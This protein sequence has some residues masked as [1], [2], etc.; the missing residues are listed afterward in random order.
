VKKYLAVFIGV[1]FLLSFTA[2]AF[3]I[4]ETVEPDEAVVAKGPTKIILGGK[5]L[6]RGW[7]FDGVSNINGRNVVPGDFGSDA[8]YTTNVNLTVDAKVSD[9]L[10]G[11][12]EFETASGG[13]ANSGLYIWGDQGRGYDSKPNADILIR[14]AWIQ[15]TGSGLLG[16]PAGLKIGHM[17]ISL[18]E[19]QFLNNERFGDDAILVWVDPMKELH[20][21][22]GTTKLN[23][24]STLSHTDDLDGYVLLA[25]YQLDKDNMIGANWLWAHSDGNCPS[26]SQVVTNDDGD[27]V[28]VAVPAP[29]VNTLNFNNIGL[30]AN[31]KI[32]GLSYAVEGDFQFGKI[33][34]LLVQPER[35]ADEDLVPV[36]VKPKGWAVYAKL[37]YNLDIVN[38]RGSFAYGSGDDDLTDD[39]CEEFQTLQGPDYGATARLIHYTQIYERTVRTAALLA[40]LT[41][42]LG[43]N[44]T[45]T[46]IANTTYYNLGVDV[47]PL[48]DVSIS[49][50]GFLLQASE[51]GAWEDFLQSNVDDSLGWEVDAKASYK[52]T[53]NLSYFV[54]AGWFSAGD[55]Y[56]DIGADDDDVKQVVHGLLFTF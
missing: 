6:V 49:V 13:S 34:D 53:K 26:D 7:Y 10:R 1:L 28:V 22:A 41:T 20:L 3:A 24:G 15:Y 36:D 56:K 23:E 40:E 9:N 51:T 54:E 14:Q 33:N 48:K 55:F 8:F 43:G 37:G 16:I 2:T 44:T 52:I 31:G 45:N 27:E 11:M 25:T 29:N 5:I 46:G 4:H 42:T 19:K 21:L 35:I 38:L 50:D 32:A 12:I 30:H 39:K 47:N 18:G 17:P